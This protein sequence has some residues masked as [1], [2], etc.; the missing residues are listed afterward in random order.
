LGLAR[1]LRIG[2]P[3]LPR[4]FDDGSLV[5][6]NH[7]QAPVLVDRLGLAQEE[8]ARVVATRAQLGRFSS[9]A[10]LAVYAELPDTTVEAAR[11]RLLF[12]P[13]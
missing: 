13:D 5:D 2:R 10:E 11:D 7:E 4:E 12:L 6:V 1:E 8:V 9:P 3:D